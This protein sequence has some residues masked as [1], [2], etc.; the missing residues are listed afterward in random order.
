M[1]Q[2]IAAQAPD[3]ILSLMRQ[4]RQDANPDKIDLTIGVYFD[5]H[6]NTP[7]MRAVKVAEAMRTETETTKTY[8]GLDGM[9]TS[10]RSC[11]N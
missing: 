3:P 6:G 7:I 9:Q 5:D 11:R 8:L 10:Q 4:A 2:H 1:F